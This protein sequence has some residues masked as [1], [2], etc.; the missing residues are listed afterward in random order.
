MTD[1][2]GLAEQLR[3][4]V[5][6]SAA[7]NVVAAPIA[8]SPLLE[9]IIKTAAQVIRARSG[10]LMLVNEAS[11]ELVFEVATSDEVSDLKHV[12]VPLGEGIAGLVALTGQP[13]AVSDAQSDPRH[14]HKIAQQTGYL[15]HSLVC[16]PLQHDD[17]I[18]GVIELLD[19]Q[20]AAVFDAN[21]VHALSLFARQAAVAIEQS[22]AQ[23]N[24]ASLLRELLGSLV[25][26]RSTE[27]PPWLQ[28]LG[29]FADELEND[30][31]FLRSLELARLGHDVAQH[32][33]DESQACLAILRGFLDY[34]RAR[35]RHT[36]LIADR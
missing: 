31:G 12:R 32:G 7:T 1:A 10:S 29:A 19:K 36:G 23:N 14:A 27:E 30:P 24:L 33:E 3:A 13:I 11:Q 18:I 17:R 34:L 26:A 15:P 35:Q 20:G 6:L 5:G 4:I 22:Q 2:D 28:R 21:D 25:D 16:V 9:M 8:R